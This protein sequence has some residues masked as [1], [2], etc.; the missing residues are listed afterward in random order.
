MFTY[1]FTGLGIE[2]YL[3]GFR[4]HNPVGYDII[5]NLQRRKVMLALITLLLLWN[6]PLGWVTALGF[7]FIHFLG[8]WEKWYMSILRGILESVALL[9]LM[10][11]TPVYKDVGAVLLCI[12]GFFGANLI[13]RLDP[14]LPNV[15]WW[16]IMS[17]WIGAWV[18]L[19]VAW[20]I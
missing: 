9:P 3:N 7:F 19:G 1:W 17:G 13:R 10:F 4:H 6:I 11:F 2:T 12:V 18:G 15:D 14:Q 5:S 8:F 20:V 16:H